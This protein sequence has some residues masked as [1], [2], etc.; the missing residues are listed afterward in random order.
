[1]T[2][3][4]RILQVNTFHHL[5]GGDSR[6][7]FE[8]T[9]GLRS[10]GH[11]VR[12][13]AMDHPQNVDDPDAAL[14]APHIDYPALMEQ[15]G[16]VNAWKV[17]RSSIANPEA[18]RTIGR[19]LDAWRPDVAHL[20]AVMHH[21]TASVVLELRERRIPIVWTLH[22]YKSVCPTTRLLRDGRPCED[23]AHGRFI[24]ATR[25]RCKRGSLAASLIT[26][27]ELT[28]HRRWRIYEDCE[29]L[30]APSQF[31]C[32]V[33]QRMGL[34]PRRIEVLY[35]FVDAKAYVPGNDHDGGYVLYVGRLSEEKGLETLVDA[36]SRVPSLEVRIAGTGELADALCARAFEHGA[37]N[38]R[39]E[40]FT[41][42][43]DLAAL[44]RNARAVVVPS[45]WYENCPM[46]V[47]ES[48]AYGRAVLGADLGGLVD[49][50]EP[51]VTGALVPP[52]DV[53]AWT[54]ALADLA[55][56]PA[57]WHTMGRH[58][59]HEAE[60]RFAATNHLDRLEAWMHEVVDIRESENAR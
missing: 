51:G 29:L 17:A 15:G 18:R 16:P 7:M 1:M 22:D 52:G 59:R 20:H 4:L 37:K 21:L 30:I 8:T 39:F 35:N 23:C 2:K 43:D 56:D 13:F 58:A 25:T 28:L 44:Y 46:V 32:D 38:I 9:A 36:A 45:E 31:L 49:L 57:R 10:R 41:S 54:N 27:I 50:V 5:R 14:F 12:H 48:F 53:D 40:G 11:E 33:V 47:L 26:S 19:M 3:P 42:G 24:N 6:V 34:R 60:T 55:T